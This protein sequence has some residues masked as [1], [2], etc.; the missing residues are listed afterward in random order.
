MPDNA[1]EWVQAIQLIITI[2]TAIYYMKN[3]YAAKKNNV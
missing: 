3:P 1:A 2:F